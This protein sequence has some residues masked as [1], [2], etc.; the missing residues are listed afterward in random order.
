MTHGKNRYNQLKVSVWAYLYRQ[1]LSYKSLAEIAE[2]CQV[3]SRGSLGNSL[4]K[5]TDWGRLQ[6]RRRRNFN[7]LE[8]RITAKGRR[9]FDSKAGEL[10][11]AIH[12]QQV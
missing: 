7:L 3:T 1:N 6:C 4:L 9:W 5:W 12:N 2:A 8:Y 11:I 10:A